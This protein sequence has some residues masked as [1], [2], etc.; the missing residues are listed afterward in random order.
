MTNSVAQQGPIAATGKRDRLV[1]SAVALIHQQGVQD[2]SLAD[3]AQTAEVPLGNVYYYFKTKDDLVAA[4]IDAH[5]QELRAT[6][7]SLRGRTPAARLKAFVQMV[8]SNSELAARYGCP[9]GTLCSELDKRDDD[10]AGRGV[11]LMELPIDWAQEQFRAMGRRDARELATALVA[12][13][14]GISLLTN[15]FR[16][17][18]LM[19]REARRLERWIDGLAREQ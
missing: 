16:D 15:T 9:I 18:E 1:A 11:Q 4:A 6:L 2:T 5:A 13:Y 3:I 7:G 10:L 19:R 17:P 8:C 12:S 14:Q